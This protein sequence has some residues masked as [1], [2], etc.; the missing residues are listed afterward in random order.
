VYTRHFWTELRNDG[1][2]MQ[3]VLTVCRSGRVV[4]VEPDLRTGDSR[5][6]L[7]GL[8]VEQQTLAVVFCFRPEDQAV[9]IT[10]FKR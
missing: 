4:Q 3:D 6:R 10:V 1:L 7:E 8:T 2:S 9:F 5:Y